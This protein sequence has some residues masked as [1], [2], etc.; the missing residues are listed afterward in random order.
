[1]N[2]IEQRSKLHLQISS[3]IAL[4]SIDSK[5]L[6]QVVWHQV[7]PFRYVNRFPRC[8]FAQKHPHNNAIKKI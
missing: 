2:K 7:A 5:M 1:M 3:S 6:G 4:I 8:F